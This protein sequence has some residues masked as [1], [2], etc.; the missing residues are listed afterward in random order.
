M[1][2][3]NCLFL[4]YHNKESW[5]RLHI[6]VAHEYPSRQV[7]LQRAERWVRRQNPYVATVLPHVEDRIVG[8]P[9]YRGGFRTGF[10]EL[11]KDRVDMGELYTR[12]QYYGRLDTQMGVTR[13]RDLY[14]RVRRVECRYK[15]AA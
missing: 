6:F 1:C 4:S 12:S 2:Q 10:Y 8:H 3:A 9:L 13:F 14:T 11:C 5:A 15:K 7:V